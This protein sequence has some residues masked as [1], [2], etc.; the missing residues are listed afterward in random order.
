MFWAEEQKY[1]LPVYT[2]NDMAHILYLDTP[3]ETVANRRR[4]NIEEPPAHIGSS[5]VKVASLGEE[6]AAETL[7][8][9]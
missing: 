3:A 9:A 5:L 8:R 4:N 7:S 6:A 1:E 2:P